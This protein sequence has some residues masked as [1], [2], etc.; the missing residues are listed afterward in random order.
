MSTGKTSGK[1]TAVTKPAKPFLKW[2]GGKGRLIP[3]LSKYY[4]ESFKI[5]YE[6]FVGGG[7]MFFSINPK[8]AHINDMNTVLIY[9]YKHIRDDAEKLIVEL[10]ALQTFYRGLPDLE[11]KKE[12]FLEKRAVF[13]ELTA[14]ELEKTV[15]LIFLNKTCFNGMYRENSKG[16]FNVPFGKQ[17]KPTICDEANLRNVS[18][19]LKKTK[20]TSL[21][22]EHAIVDAA[23]D[24]F[25]YFDPPYHPLNTTSSF[26]S[27]QAGGFGADDQEKL[28]DT[29]KVLSDRGCKVMLSNSDAPL[30]NEL[31]KDFNI[32]KI[33]AAR[34]INA[35]GSKRGKILE[36]L[37]T[38]Y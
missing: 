27:Y 21:S 37:V 20:I 1:D 22:Y 8:A 15:L 6:P 24:D 4:P 7:A 5:F 35:T 13:N 34:S 32:Y 23:K 33:Y 11:K 3:E 9:A 2:V 38:N 25:V 16:G 31:Y 18:K 17:E 36:V 28:R 30:I 14:E 10:D 29:F 26:T 19:A 12:L